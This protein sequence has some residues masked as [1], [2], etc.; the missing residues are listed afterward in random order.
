MHTS[1]H[2]SSR[3]YFMLSVDIEILSHEVVSGMDNAMQ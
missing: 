3:L 1:Y 2:E